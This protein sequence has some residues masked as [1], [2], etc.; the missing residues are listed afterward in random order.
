MKND[1]TVSARVILTLEIACRGA[2]G[3]DC[4]LDQ[5]E[6][7]AASEAIGAC[8]RG[9]RLLGEGEP[10]QLAATVIGQPQVTAVLVKRDR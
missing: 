1:V 6:K 8:R 10:A 2:W 5:V 3:A 9:F 7:Q 4:A